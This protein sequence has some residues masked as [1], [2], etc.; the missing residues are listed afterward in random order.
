MVL[1]HSRIGLMDRAVPWL[2]LPEGAPGRNSCWEV[3][4]NG[5]RVL[6]ACHR[7]GNPAQGLL[8]GCL[9]PCG[10]GERRGSVPVGGI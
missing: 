7:P 8:L 3:P 4:G 5:E 2:P 6:G 9:G 1:G 10:A